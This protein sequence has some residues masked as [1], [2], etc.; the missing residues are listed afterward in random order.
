V[1]PVQDLHQLAV[2]L[3]DDAFLD[4]ASTDQ[5][6]LSMGLFVRRYSIGQDRW[7]GFGADATLGPP[8]LLSGAL[9][10]AVPHNCTRASTWRPSGK[11]CR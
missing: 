9:R 7:S 1:A 5:I 10:A 8:S 4:V 3:D 2:E 6:P 11:A